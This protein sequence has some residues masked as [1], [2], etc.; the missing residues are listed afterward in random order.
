MSCLSGSIGIRGCGQS[1]ASL[2]INDLTGINVP[3]FDKVVNVEH[4]NGI[5]ALQTIIETAESLVL[6]DI[7][8]Y[9]K[10]KFE[11][12]SIIDN[13]TVG[14]FYDNKELISAATG[15]YIGYEVRVDKVPYVDFYLSQIRLFVNN[16]GTVNVKVWDL[17]QGKVIKTVAVSAVAGEIVTV[18]NVDLCVKSQKQRIHLFIGYES[19]FQSYRTSYVSPYA[20]S[21]GYES[22]GKLCG[23]GYGVGDQIYVSQRTMPTS[24]TPVYNSLVGSDTPGG[25]S[26]GY[27]LQCSFDNVICNAR[28]QFD[29]A[30]WYKCGE[31]IM[32]EMKHSKRLN[33]VVTCYKDSHDELMKFYRNEHIQK[34][35]DALLTMRMPESICWQCT[36]PV[37]TRTQL[38]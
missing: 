5:A 9:L 33:G 35:A 34:M 26:I 18:D 25:L 16:T 3:D 29:Q 31:L 37:R 1:S 24:A 22:C 13:D 28:N 11:L 14:Y 21:P 10:G 7:N 4:K 38:P 30:I 8:N 23:Y 6:L 12:R 32:Q 15:S 20:A 36:P 2:Y 19:T 27:S 17:I